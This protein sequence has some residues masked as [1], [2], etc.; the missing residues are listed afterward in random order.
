MSPPLILAVNAGSS[1]LKLSLFILLVDRNDLKPKQEPVSLLATSSI[2]DIGTSN[3]KF[4]YSLATSPLPKR[5]LDPPT[6]ESVSDHTAA[7]KYFLGVLTSDQE[8]LK[9]GHGQD[10]ITHVCHR[11]VHGGQFVDSVI[12]EQSAYE[13][14]QALSDLAPLCVIAV[15]S[16]IGFSPTDILDITTG[17]FLL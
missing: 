14:L 12:M 11:I 8:F 2:S 3:S 10:S 1:S 7:F 16:M 13:R 9:S 5:H 17:P 6:S 15:S 4:S